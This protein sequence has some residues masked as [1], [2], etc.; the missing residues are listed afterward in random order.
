MLGNDLVLKIGP[1]TPLK[2]PEVVTC[3]KKTSNPERSGNLITV[4][5]KAKIPKLSII[6]TLF[7]YTIKATEGPGEGR[8]VGKA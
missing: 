3:I 1:K 4:F 7:R 5:I 6:P 8:W 2:G